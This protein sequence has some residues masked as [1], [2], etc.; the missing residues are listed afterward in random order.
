MDIY[1]KSLEILKN[2]IESEKKYNYK[3]FLLGG[4]AV[5]FYNPYMKSKDIDFIV[6]KKHFWKFRNFIKGLGFRETSKILQ[7]HGF[8]MMWKGDKIEIDVYTEKIRKWHVE[9][10]LQDFQ[11]IKGVRVLSP[12]NLFMLKTF[13]ALERHGTAKGEKDM[14][15]LLALLDAEYKKIDFEFVKNHTDL[16]T[17]LSIILFNFQTASKLYPIEMKKYKEIKAYLKNLGL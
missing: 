4:W 2:I 13:T 6:E 7:K 12:T 8:S 9:E 17:I 5:W 11:K 1:N 3:I 15:D 14:S 10:L 16:Q